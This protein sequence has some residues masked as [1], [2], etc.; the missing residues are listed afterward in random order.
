MAADWTVAVDDAL[1]LRFVHCL[2]CMQ[3]LGAG[4][5]DAFRLGG[6]VVMVTRCQQCCRG[7]LAGARVLARRP[8]A[9]LLTPA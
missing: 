4:R 9:Q 2:L 5:L 8:D 6:L 1:T 7:D 3:P